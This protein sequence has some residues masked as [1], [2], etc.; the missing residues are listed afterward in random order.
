MPFAICNE[1]FEGW[2][3]EDAMS[4]AAKAGYDANLRLAATFPN[5]DT[6]DGASVVAAL[7]E[8]FP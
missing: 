8:E 5:P 3:L 1:I 6:A 4:F 7:A 2:E